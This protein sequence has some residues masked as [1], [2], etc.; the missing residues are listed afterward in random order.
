MNRMWATGCAIVALASIV[1]AGCGGS[2][3][4]DSEDSV[5]RP[6]ANP[7]VFH[8]TEYD[9][10]TTW[11]Q[12]VSDEKVGGYLQSVWADPGG[13]EFHLVIDSRPSEGAATP[14]A[15]AESARAK[16]SSLAGYKER[17]FEKITPFK[18]PTGIYY[19]YGIGEEVFFRFFFAECGTS[20][21]LYG[22][23]SVTAASDFSY[24]YRVVASRM[25]PVCNE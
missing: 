8:Q 4:A 2:S 10:E 17:H 15:A 24:F 25:K 6:S 16:A 18:G 7:P 22:N 13:P 14:L 11:N 21:F 1:L 5:K 3:S 12:K 23:S 19:V 20:V 9:V